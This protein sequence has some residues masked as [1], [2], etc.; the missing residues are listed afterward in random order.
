MDVKY[1]LESILEY[2]YN[3]VKSGSDR[4]IV[5]DDE[6]L[7]DVKTGAEYHLF[8]D[9]FKITYGGNVVATL[10]DFNVEESKEQAIVME[11]KE[12]ITDPAKSKERKERYEVQRLERRAAFAALYADPQPVPPNSETVEKGTVAY[13]G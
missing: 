6:H 11:I 12:L 7:K 3:G 2:V 13:T 8:D 1:S 10:P 9:N 4:F 5:V